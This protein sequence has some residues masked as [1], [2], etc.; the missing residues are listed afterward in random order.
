VQ[1]LS[2]NNNIGL[3]VKWKSARMEEDRLTYASNIHQKS[4]MHKEIACTSLNIKSRRPE[5]QN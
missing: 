2:E 1:H 3:I 4:N 5:K